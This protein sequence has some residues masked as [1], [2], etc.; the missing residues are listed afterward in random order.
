M[1]A[2]RD[3]V[4][5]AVGLEGR[6]V[7]L[8]AARCISGG[9]GVDDTEE[10]SNGKGVEATPRIVEVTPEKT[11]NSSRFGAANG[12]LGVCATL[13]LSVAFSRCLFTMGCERKDVISV[14]GDEIETHKHLDRTTTKWRSAIEQ[15]VGRAEFHQCSLGHLTLRCAHRDHSK[16]DLIIGSA[17]VRQCSLI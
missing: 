2:G 5:D 4:C 8:E 13:K 10:E 16:D 3:E 12:S 14:E 1:P 7:D 6:G 15:L 17:P 9:L 11:A